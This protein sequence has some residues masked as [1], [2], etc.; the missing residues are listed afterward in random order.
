MIPALIAFVIGVALGSL[1]Q[2]WNWASNAKAIQ[3]KEWMGKLYKVV[4][5]ATWDAMEDRKDAYNQQA[6]QGREK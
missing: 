6:M 1:L 3:R 4:P 2:G 5:A